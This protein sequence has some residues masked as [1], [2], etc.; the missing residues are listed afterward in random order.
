MTAKPSGKSPDEWE[1]IAH[2]QKA[3]SEDMLI[4]DHACFVR[5]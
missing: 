4:G 1:D 5:T 2:I 3:S